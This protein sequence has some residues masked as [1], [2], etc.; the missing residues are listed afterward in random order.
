MNRAMTVIFEGL[1]LTGRLIR[2]TWHL[3]YGI[4][5]IR[6]LERP[7]VSIFGSHILREPSTYLQEAHEC[8]RLLN[9]RGISV[10]TGGGHGI[11]EAAERGAPETAFGIGVRGLHERPKKSVSY[12]IEM[13]YFWSRK[14]LLL[15]YSKGFI[16]F[17]GGF[18]TMD[19]LSELLNLMHVKKLERSPVILIGVQFWHPYKQWLDEALEQKLI[20][21][22]IVSMITITDDLIHAVSLIEAHCKSLSI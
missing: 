9:E 4:W 6:K 13:D 12:F 19:E 22:H 16:V 1:I 7:L 20:S 18:G 17:P 21:K 14:W 8:A 2:G 5:K 3:L 10:L 11:M 15:D